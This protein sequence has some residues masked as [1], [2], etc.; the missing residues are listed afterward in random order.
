VDCAKLR[1]CQIGFLVAA[2]VQVSLIERITID[3]PTSRPSS[4]FS[5]ASRLRG[6]IKDAVI[7][8]VNN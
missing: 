2:Q 4:L 6:P 3:R 1:A 8:I 5:A 7:V